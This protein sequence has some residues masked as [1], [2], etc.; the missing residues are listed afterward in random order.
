MDVDTSSGVEESKV[1]G[2]PKPVTAA[3]RMEGWM[4]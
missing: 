3:V 2:V 4:G 1:S